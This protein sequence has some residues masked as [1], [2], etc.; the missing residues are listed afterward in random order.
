[1]SLFISCD[2]RVE[3][4]FNA[5]DDKNCE[6]LS[7]YLKNGFDINFYDSCYGTP[8][9]RSINNNSLDM[10]K[11]MLDNGSDIN[12]K[13]PLLNALYCQNVEIANYLIK[14]GADLS[15][16]D[17]K[18]SSIFHYISY[19]DDE[20]FIRKIINLYNGDLS[21]INGINK[22]K[23]SPLE[24]ACG[25]NNKHVVKILIENGSNVN[26]K[27][28]TKLQSNALIRAIE[29]NNYNLCKYLLDNGTDVN[30]G[31]PRKPI[32]V[33]SIIGNTD[34]LNLLIDNGA[35]V[36]VIDESEKTP[37]MI[38]SSIGNETIV[39]LL[40]A[41]GANVNEQNKEGFTA[42]LYS[43]NN[44]HQKVFEKLLSYG[45]D[46]FIKND[47]G[48]SAM[49]EMMKKYSKNKKSS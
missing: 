39:E 5:I 24:R 30:F 8:L 31:F 45:A 12:L 46:V 16:K 22:I 42:I 33:A 35:D 19:I 3:T 26:F 15:V 7:K 1:M 37:L 29:N 49:T 21:E 14:N 44:H 47:F 4:F 41:S 36:N 18:G 11:F 28:K 2:K 38:A 40:I 13:H 43:L 10:V 48:E 34:I 25:L 17:D 6:K 27:G 32:N 20:F 23:E 9:N